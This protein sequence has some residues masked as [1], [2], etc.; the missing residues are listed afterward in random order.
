MLANISGY[1]SGVTT[2]LQKLNGAF[3]THRVV[4]SYFKFKQCKDWREEGE[5]MSS[6]SYWKDYKLLEVL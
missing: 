1:K 2:L 6:A 3:F 5:F 4:N